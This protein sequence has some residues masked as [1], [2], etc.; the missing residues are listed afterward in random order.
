LVIAHDDEDIGLLQR[1]RGAAIAKK[2]TNTY[3]S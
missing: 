2:A 1:N 3:A